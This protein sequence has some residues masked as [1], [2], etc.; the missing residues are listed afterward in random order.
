MI[1]QSPFL[2]VYMMI[3]VASYMFTLSVY[4]L[5]WYNFSIEDLVQI[6]SE[7]VQLGNLLSDHIYYEN[8]HEFD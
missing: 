7:I 4:T 6:S 3:S 5:L 1:K 8:K 2:N